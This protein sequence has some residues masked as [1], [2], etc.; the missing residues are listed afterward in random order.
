LFLDETIHNCRPI[1]ESLGNMSVR[2]VRHSEHFKSGALDTEWLPYVGTRGWAVLTCDK[3]IRYNQ[4]E[5]DK[6]MQYGVR[7]FVFTSGNLSG[8]MMGQVIRTAI[9][10]MQKLFVHHPAPFVACISQ[11]GQVEVRYDRHGSVDARKKMKL[12]KK[13]R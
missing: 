4:L 11:T 5:R 13:T 10:R 1:H 2:Y 9:P 7:E 8:A 6:V 3:R 12:R